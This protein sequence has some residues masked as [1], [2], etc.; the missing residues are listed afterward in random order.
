VSIALVERT[1]DVVLTISDD[2]G[3]LSDDHDGRSDGT[4]LSI[5]RAL[6]KDELQGT[7]ELRNRGGLE[8]E[9]AFP[10]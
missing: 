10:S 2:G 5:V 3:G 7:L 1:G 9:V 8:A 6:V 4:G